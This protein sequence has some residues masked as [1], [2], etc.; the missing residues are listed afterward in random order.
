MPTEQEIQRL[1]RRYA[2]RAEGE[3]TADLCSYMDSESS[4]I[5]EAA[6]RKFRGVDRLYFRQ[7]FLYRTW[8]NK[9]A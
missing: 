9:H 5:L 7:G 1:Q 2:L 6:S 3:N 4:L 8:E